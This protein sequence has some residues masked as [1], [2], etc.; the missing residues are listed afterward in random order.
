MTASLQTPAA[1]ATA[2]SADSCKHS[3]GR[4]VL[5]GAGAGGIEGVAAV[6]SVGS[7]GSV[8]I[9]ESAVVVAEREE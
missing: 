8:V 4:L 3:P 2:L 7:V 6:G 1:V 5:G 9:V